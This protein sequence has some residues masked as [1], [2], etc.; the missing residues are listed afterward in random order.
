MDENK[1]QATIIEFKTRDFC[2]F[3]FNNDANV[4][5]AVSSRQGTTWN[6]KYRRD[7]KEKGNPEFF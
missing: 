2:N 3:F 5:L 4:G 6:S 1:S 7:L